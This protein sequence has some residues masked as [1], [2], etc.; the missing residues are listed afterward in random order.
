MD[1]L[2]I[3]SP[4]GAFYAFP[5]IHQ[6]FEKST[7]A[8]KKIT[9]SMTFCE[10]LLEDVNVPVFRYRVWPEGYLRLSYATADA[11]IDEG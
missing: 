11:N 8:G 6:V 4:Q 10:A 1:G 7:K 2:S 9:N 5:S 3:N